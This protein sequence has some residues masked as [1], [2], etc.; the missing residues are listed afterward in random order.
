MTTM[1]EQD[2]TADEYATDEHDR[3]MELG[4]PAEEKQTEPA[5]QLAAR[6][7]RPRS[8]RLLDRME[9]FARE[10][11]GAVTAE[12]ALIITAAVA[13]AGVLILIVRSDEVRQMLLDLVQSALGGIG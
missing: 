6:A 4:F 11:R 7:R 5:Q 13:F 3:L 1:T 10:E 9:D 2:H 12:Y 8:M